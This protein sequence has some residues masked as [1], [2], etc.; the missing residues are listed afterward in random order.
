MIKIRPREDGAGLQQEP[1]EGLP[2]LT[3][4][5]VLVDVRTDPRVPEPIRNFATW[6][7][8]Y[9]E[10][11]GL[12]QYPERYT[13]AHFAEIQE[14]ARDFGVLMHEDGVIEIVKQ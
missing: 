7:D 9:C 4:E 10:R 1:V 8:G 11:Q 2:P 6:L 13:M 3:R 14:K 12:K 5:S